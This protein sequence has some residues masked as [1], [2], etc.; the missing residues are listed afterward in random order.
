MMT[1][2]VK[3]TIVVPVYK[4]EKYLD[5]CVSSLINQTLKNIEI[6]LVDDGSPD[7]CPALCDAF[8]ERDSRIKVIHKAN[9]G[10]ASARN[11]GLKTA[12]GEYVGFV[13]SD[14]DVEPDMYESMLNIAESESVDFVMCDYKRILSDGTSY[15][16]T[17]GIKTG[18]YEKPDIIRDIWPSLIMSSHIDYGPLLSVWHCLYKTQFL[19]QNHIE[20]ND[21][22]RW[23]E[24]NIFSS[25]AGYHADSFYYMKGHAYYHYY[26]NEGTITTSYRKGSWDVYKT[27]NRHLKDFFNNKKEHDFSQQLK[28]HMIYYA[29][30]CIGQTAML[31]KAERRRVIAEVVRSSELADALDHADLHDV[32]PK[33]K[34]QLML[35]KLKNVYLLDKMIQRRSH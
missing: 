7:S 2:Y 17:L 35:M 23:S 25:F 15:I 34:I 26:Q 9:G 30:N 29:C 24:D 32:N 31:D 16:K 14:D 5:R 11:A 18:K 13:D 22:V 4:V 19:A 20:F 27:M 21:D 28:W 10:L 6:I 3:V 1:D 33:L 12:T 8:A